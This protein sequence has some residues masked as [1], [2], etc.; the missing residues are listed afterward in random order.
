M[1]RHLAAITLAASII[2]PVQAGDFS[3][4]EELTAMIAQLEAEQ[5]YAPG[6]LASLF[7]FVNRNDNT[8]ERIAKPAESKE[9]KD[10]RPL[11]MTE[12][13]I[14]DGLAFWDQYRDAFVRAE[15]Q[16]GVPQKMILAILGVETKYGFNKGGTRVIEALATLGFD[17]PP[18]APFFRSELREFLV[19]TKQ[20]GMDPLAVKGSYAGAMGFPQFMPSSWRKLAIDFDGDGRID[21]INNPVDAI[22]SI[23]NYFKANGWQPGGLVTVRARISGNGY[24]SATSKELK[25]VSTLADMERQGLT[26]RNPLPAGATTPA[27]G[28]RLQGT[29]GAEFWIA[30]NNFYVITKYN[31]SILY[32]M[33]AHQLADAL[34]AA[35]TERDQAAS[36]GGSAEGL[37]RPPL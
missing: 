7:E 36:L 32:A 25:T 21:L 13:R 37:P 27:S 35:R 12:A 24:D 3:Q 20:N 1:K 10:Y 31:R 28:I 34:E 18:R 19:L 26:P 30:F 22:G 6:E 23:A 29:N 15:A 16:T 8:L 5:I 2:T 4:Y 11:F 14:R 17:Y 9:W 33:A